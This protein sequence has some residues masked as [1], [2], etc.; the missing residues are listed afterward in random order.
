[1]DLWSRC[2]DIRPRANPARD[3]RGAS[4]RSKAKRPATGSKTGSG[5]LR[6]EHFADGSLKSAGR[7]TNGKKTGPWRFYHRNGTLWASGSFENGKCV[8]LWKWFADNG[9]LRQ[10]GRFENNMQVGVWKRYRGGTG[11]LY[12]EGRYINGKKTGEWMVYDKK[13]KAARREKF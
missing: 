11:Q 1:M 3:E 2:D 6:K 10:V 5:G 9:A 12:D 13:G 7:I 8:G 4:V